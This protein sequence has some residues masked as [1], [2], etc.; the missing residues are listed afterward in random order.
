MNSSSPND[1]TAQTAGHESA[2]IRQLKAVLDGFG[3][4]YTI[5][6]HEQNIATAQDGAQTGL[7]ALSA[8]APTFILQTEKGFLAAVIR[9][10][11]RLSYKK[12]K[13]ELGLKNIS[14]ASPEQVKEL[15]GAEVGWVSL[16]NPGLPTILDARLT[17]L[18]V[19]NG[20]S[21]EP[22]HTLQISPQAVI[23]VTQARVFDFTEFK[24]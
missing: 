10:D 4:V 12:I 13:R 20:G 5:L 21:G 3:V 17:E 8:M 6:V 23:Q 9:G 15:T 24:D 2:R 22:K 11:T 18:A 19:V 16:V 14:L 7:G 1:P